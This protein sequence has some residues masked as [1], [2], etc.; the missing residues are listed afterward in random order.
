MVSQ[1]DCEDEIEI[2]ISKE[3]EK[4]YYSLCVYGSF[5]GLENREDL[6]ELYKAF[7]RILPD[8]EVLALFEV[9][10]ERLRYVDGSTTIITNETYQPKSLHSVATKLAR[11][12]TN[13]SNYMLKF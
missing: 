9:G 1:I 6:S 13:N 5:M 7:Q 4:T 3:N 11:I 10:H 12:I 2:D 8:G